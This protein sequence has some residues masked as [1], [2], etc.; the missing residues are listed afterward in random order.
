MCAEVRHRQNPKGLQ[1]QEEEREEPELGYQRAQVSVEH[2][3]LLDQLL[4]GNKDTGLPTWYSGQES[5]CSAGDVGLIPGP[6]RFHMLQNIR[7]HTP[8]H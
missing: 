3:K 5:A 1:P 4:A 2:Y 6:G 7:A 8:N